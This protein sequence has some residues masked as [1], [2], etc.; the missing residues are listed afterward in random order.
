[1][2]AIRALVLTPSEATGGFD[3]AGADREGS[4]VEE[5]SEPSWEPG[6]PS[7][8]AMAPSVIGG[9]VVPLS[10]YYVVRHHVS[11]DAP[12]LMIA[13]LFPAAWVAIQ[14]RRTRQLDPIGA[15][16]LF[17]FIAGVIASE[18]LG[19]NALVLKIRDS[20]FTALFGL[21]CLI[22]LTWHRPMM[23]HIGKALSAGDDEQRR[24]AYDELWEFEAAQRV[25][26]VITTCWGIGLIAEAA[27]RIVLAV[28]LPTGPF[29]AVSPILGFTTFGSLF[30]F[31]TVYSRRA[32]QAG[33][34]DLVEQGR[35]FPSVAGSP[36]QTG[37]EG[38]CG[39]TITS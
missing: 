15:I 24:A 14:W 16:T 30:A 27:A 25:F 33:E 19:G 17:G 1:M 10:V 34:A 5:E 32:R 12:A 28:V 37:S 4:G 26:A 23:F 22:S 18:L 29:L 39:G 38:R 2:T 21:T 9:V 11:G 7:V 6:A 36:A 3:G 8:R 13:G 35:T 20:A 31:T